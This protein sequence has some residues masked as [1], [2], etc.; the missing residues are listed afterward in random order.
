VP[1]PN[2]PPR[3]PLISEGHINYYVDATV[4]I[5]SGLCKSFRGAMFTISK[6]FITF[7]CKKD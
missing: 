5:D 1:Q 4:K 6:A 2:A 3:A 7:H